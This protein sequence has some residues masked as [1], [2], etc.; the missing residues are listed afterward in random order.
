M[1]IDNHNPRN[2]LYLGISG[3]LHPSRTTYQL[4]N[5]RSPKS[6]GHRLYEATPV[7]ERVLLG[8]PSVQIVLTST[9]PWAHGLPRV[10]KRLGPVIAARVLGFTYEDLT[11]K[12]KHGLRQI[13]MSNENYWRSSHEQIVKM[14]VEWLKPTGWVAVDDNA[15]IWTEHER[16]IHIVDVDGSKG[17][18]DPV[19]QDRLLTYMTGQFGPA[20][21]GGAITGCRQ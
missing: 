4:V 3:V 6:D 15:S 12:V 10:L 20:N 21:C 14:H 11:T 13:P 5:R 17:L 8:W 7:V 2:I 18:L 16:R 1:D 9:L 19:A